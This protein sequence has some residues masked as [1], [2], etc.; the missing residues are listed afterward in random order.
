M[1]H[2]IITERQWLVATPEQRGGMVMIVR[3]TMMILKRKRSRRRRIL[4]FFL[5]AQK[6]S[7]GI[8]IREINTCFLIFHSK[9]TRQVKGSHVKAR[10]RLLD[11]PDS[12]EKENTKDLLHRR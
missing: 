4:F 6:T 3:M 5:H 2:L 11:D 10:D 8:R 9:H 7:E 12:H 1:P